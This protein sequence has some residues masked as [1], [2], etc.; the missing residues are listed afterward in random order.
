MDEDGRIIKVKRTRIVKKPKNDILKNMKLHI[1]KN[2][3]PL[4]QAMDTF[5]P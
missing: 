1:E 4:E 5:D 2:G 3:S